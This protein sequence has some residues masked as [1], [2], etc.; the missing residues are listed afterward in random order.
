MMNTPISSPP[1]SSSAL[2]KRIRSLGH[3]LLVLISFSCA[4]LPRVGS[5]QVFSNP[6]PIDIP[7]NS[8]Q[9]GPGSLYPSSITVF[10]VGTTLAGITITF[11]NLSHAYPDDIDILL[12]GP[13]GQNVLLMSDAGGLFPINNLTFTFDSAAASFLPDETVLSSGTFL[14]TN[15][16]AQFMVDSFAAPAPLTG[17]YGNSLT[18]FNG[19]NPNG[20]WNLYVLDDTQGNAGILA[21]GWSLSITAVPEPSS[22]ALATCGLVGVGLAALRRRRAKAFDGNKSI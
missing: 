22:I 14:P 2:A 4:V 5:A 15:Y 19:T 18:A 1:S 6:A 11:I 12:V 13:N 7:R 10:G 3:G 8:L 21:G 16:D 9:Q 20:V 17:P